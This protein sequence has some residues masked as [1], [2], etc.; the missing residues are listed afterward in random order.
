MSAFLVTPLDGKEFRKFEGEATPAQI[1]EF[2][3]LVGSILYLACMLRPDGAFAS[4]KLS[5]YLT[6]PSPH[7][8]ANAKRS[9]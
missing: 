7:Y 2:Q 8:M 4:S 3:E 5:Q 1:K 9:I 6:N